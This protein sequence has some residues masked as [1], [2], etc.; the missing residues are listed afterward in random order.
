LLGSGWARDKLSSSTPL[1]YYKY[2]EFS[3]TFEVILGRCFTLE[4]VGVALR[5]DTKLGLALDAFVRSFVEWEPEF[6]VFFD[7]DIRLKMLE[8]RDNV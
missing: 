8:V 1:N 5:L 3:R 4:L 6:L 7:Y 2:I